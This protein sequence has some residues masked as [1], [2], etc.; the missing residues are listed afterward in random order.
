MK[1][2]KPARSI[3]ININEKKELEKIKYEQNRSYYLKKQA[4]YRENN[5]ERILEYQRERSQKM[6]E[7]LK[8]GVCKLNFKYKSSGFVL[9]ETEDDVILAVGVIK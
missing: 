6:K 7:K 1:K 3:P 9:K 2:H 4:I 5:K 8:S